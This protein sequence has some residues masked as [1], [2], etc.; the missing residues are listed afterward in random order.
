MSLSGL[1]WLP[2]DDAWPSRIKALEQE[3]PVDWD[4][5]VALA[6]ARLDFIRTERLDRLLRRAFGDAPPAGLATKPVRLALLASSTVAHLQPAIRVAALR[7]GLWCTIYE[8]EYGQ[9]LREL[10]DPGSGLHRFKPDTVLFALDAR[11]LT[12]AA[13]VAADAGQAGGIFDEMARRL[14]EGWRLARAAFGAAVLQ[15]TVLPVLPMVMGGN[16][17]RAPGAPGALVMRLNAALRGL[18]DKAGV[19]LLALD[20]HA[21]G[22]GTWAWHDPVL[23]HRAKQDVSPAAAPLYGDL[24][25]RIL[26]A[27]QG[28]SAKCLVLDLDNT[29]WGGVIGDD[30]LEGIELGQGSALGEA[31]VAFQDY[32]RQLARRGVILAVCSKNDAADALAPFEHHPEM[33]LTRSDIA[34]FAVNWQDKVSNLRAVAREL[35]IGLDALVFVDDSPF[36]RNLVRQELPM[37]R[38][39]ELPDDPALFAQCLADAGYFE[40]LGVT[41]EDRNRTRFYQG[42]RARETLQAQ[43]TDIA[44][45]LRGLGMRMVWRRFDA[46]GLGRI[47]QLINR[48]NQFNLTTRRYAEEQV[49][50]LIDDPRIVGLQLRLLDR[51][52]DNG[53]IA[54]VIGR[55]QESGDFLIDTW[56][57]SCRVLGRQVEEATLNLVAAEAGRRGAARIV[58]DYIPSPRNGMVAA[59]Y[60]RL[61]FTAAET[62]PDGT[63]RSVLWLADFAPRDI[64]IEI[65]DGVTP[66]KE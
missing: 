14:A 42:D 18:A 63:I 1:Y 12:A 3:G 41:D 19:S 39:P 20:E 54:I 22:D 11:H 36:E 56:L 29:L 32:A 62:T 49:R 47:V 51:F 59:H 24:V 5:L 40:G 16:E 57:M 4:A 9:Y 31:F 52:G 58:G 25:A 33:L 64:C 44:S 60:Q 34:A 61:G 23:W 26:G 45:Y 30:G 37:V 10:L 46:V 48:T 17:H 43:A 8:T 27:Q 7:R 38:V 66:G 50:A 15:Q 6:N 53:I 28:L 21:R 55:L 13:D 65:V 35:K 2:S